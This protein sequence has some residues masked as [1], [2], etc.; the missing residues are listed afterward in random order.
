MCNKENRIM[1]DDTKNMILESVAT[2]TVRINAVERILGEMTH[3]RV[4][5][6]Y[7]VVKSVQS[8]S[9]KLDFMINEL[10]DGIEFEEKKMSGGVV[11]VER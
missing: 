10:I 2:I 1:S 8:L 5:N 7:N 9:K 3:K 6:T 4:W 11:N